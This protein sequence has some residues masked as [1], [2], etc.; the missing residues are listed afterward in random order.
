MQIQVHHVHAEV[1][2]TGLA[3]QGIHVGA[4]H[5]EQGALGVEDVG[6]L[7]N[8]TLED[9]NGA[10]IGEHQRGRVFADNPLQLGDI[11]HCPA[12][13]SAG[14]PPGTRRWPP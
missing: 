6:D 14:S 3:D 13:W 2:G 1:P 5:V 12:H 7:M 4:V 11:N 9:A 8:L 10:G